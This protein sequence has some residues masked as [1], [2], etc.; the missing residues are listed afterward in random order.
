MD[1]NKPA[2]G[3]VCASQKS[4]STSPKH[5]S[6]SE[7]LDHFIRIMGKAS[8]K[9]TK[10]LADEQ[11]KHVLPVRNLVNG[12]IVAFTST[13]VMREMLEQLLWEKLQ[14]Y[15]VAHEADKDV[16]Q[17]VDRARIN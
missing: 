2:V 1:D 14:A 13:W 16:K 3:A 8:F 15:R 9:W 4:D 10:D 17:P 6:V 5:D 7:S 11:S 12:E